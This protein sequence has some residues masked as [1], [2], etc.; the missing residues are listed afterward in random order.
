MNRL[1]LLLTAAALVF[2]PSCAGLSGPDD[3][4][5]V[6]ARNAAIRAE[7]RGDYFIGRRYFTDKT[8]YW[9]YLRQPGQT[10]ETAKLAVMDENRGVLTPDRLKEM[11]ESGNAHGFD[12]NYEYK[13]WGSYTGGKCY[14]PNADMEL[15]LFAARKYELVNEKPGF[16]FKPSDR[17]NPKYIPAREAHRQTEGRR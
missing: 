14:D 9:G 13:V 17:Y 4:P 1:F 11:P 3:G 10:W 5:A 16:L 6:A 7:P 2:L 8:R 12:H 15:P